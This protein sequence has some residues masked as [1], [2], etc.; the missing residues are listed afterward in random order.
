MRGR[1]AVDLTLLG[2]IWGGSYLLTRIGVPAFGPFAFIAL[3][4]GFGALVVL[5]LLAWHRELHTL[6]D[7]PGVQLVAG[8]LN[9]SVPF[10]LIAWALLHLTAGLV[11]IVGALSPPLT[12]LVARVWTGERLTRGKVVGLIAGVAGVA[13][14]TG[15]RAAVT[16]EHFAL[17]VLAVLGGALCYAI[18]GLYVKRHATGIAPR[19]LSAGSLLWGAASVAPLAWWMWPDAPITASNW[20]IVAVVGT[21]CTGFAYLVYYRIVARSGPQVAILVTFLVPLTGMVWGWLCLDEPVT[22]RMAVGCAA[23]LTGTAAA[24]GVGW[25][26][27]PAVSQPLAR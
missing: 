6:G 16:G 2:T 11:A 18:G 21:L 23:I 10:V 24:T 3:R 20:G 8:L 1:D 26:R 13:V 27:P 9:S 25:R 19:T 15:D 22:W 17:P 4:L 14:L 12:G 5:A 7:R